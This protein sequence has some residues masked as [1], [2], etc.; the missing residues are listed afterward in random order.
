MTKG[1]WVSR[2]LHVTI[3]LSFV[4]GALV[5]SAYLNAVLQV[6]QS[7]EISRNRPIKGF[8]QLVRIILFVLTGIL[9][10]AILFN[11]SPFGLLGGLGALTAVLVLVFKDTILGLVASFQISSGKLV[12][13][14]DWIEFPKYG[15]DGD[16]IDIS[17]LQVQVQNWDKTISNIPTYALVSDSFKNW[18]GMSESGGR[19]I[20]RSLKIDMN[21]VRFCDAEMIERFSRVQYIA[22]YVQKKREE[23]SICSENPI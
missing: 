9:V 16:V 15:A 3:A 2:V 18:R 10:I 12:R 11:Q 7:S 5:V 4:V 23:L 14:G 8:L 19:R 22:E 17:L 20:K 21:T 1:K 6:Y 13:V